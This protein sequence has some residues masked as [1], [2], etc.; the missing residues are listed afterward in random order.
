M[1]E[2]SPV[3]HAAVDASQRRSL[4]IAPADF[5]LIARNDQIAAIHEFLESLPSRLIA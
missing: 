5:E 1:L 4:A 3:L 2:E